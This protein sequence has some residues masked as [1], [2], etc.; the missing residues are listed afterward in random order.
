LVDVVSSPIYA[1]AVGLVVFGAKEAMRPV[2]QK[3]AE[4][5]VYAKVANRMKQWFGD[6]F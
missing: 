1:T 6:F 4:T 3:G 2:R 5:T